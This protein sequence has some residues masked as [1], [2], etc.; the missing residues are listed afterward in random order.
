MSKLYNLTPELSKS[1]YEIEEYS[2]EINDELITI[3]IST[4]FRWSEF[5]INLDNEEK[6]ELLNKNNIVLNEKY[7]YEFVCSNDGLSREL[8]IV[9]EEKYSKDFINI[10]KESIYGTE[11]D[12]YDDALNELEENGWTPGDVSYELSCKCIL[13]EIQE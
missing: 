2:K 3:C 9:N 8:K 13:N 4:L 11:D 1:S 10:I 6:E 12:P 5:E 7:E